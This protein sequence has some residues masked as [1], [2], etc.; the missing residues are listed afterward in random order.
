MMKFN[1]WRVA[2]GIVL[3][4][5]GGCADIEQPTPEPVKTEDPVQ[6]PPKGLVTTEDPVVKPGGS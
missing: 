5:C 3:L 1:K 2:C 6:K 4:S